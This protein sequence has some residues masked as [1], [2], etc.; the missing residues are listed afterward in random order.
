MKI[1]PAF[2][3]A[4]S[5]RATAY[6]GTKS[7]AVTRDFPILEVLDIRRDHMGVIGI[8]LRAIEK[9]SVPLAAECTRLVGGAGGGLSQTVI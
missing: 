7:N 3:F 1:R 5:C 2:S 6:D 4:A 8:G 9:F